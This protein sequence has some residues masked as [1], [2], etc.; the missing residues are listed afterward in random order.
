MCMKKKLSLKKLAVQ[1]FVTEVNNLPTVKGGVQVG[2]LPV[3]SCLFPCYTEPPF[4]CI[5]P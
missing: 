4:Y 5:E 3:A 2:S 1:S